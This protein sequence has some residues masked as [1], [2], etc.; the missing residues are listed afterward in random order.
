RRVTPA[1]PSALEGLTSVFGKGTG[2]SPPPLSPNPEIIPR[3][4][5]HPLP[6]PSTRPSPLKGEG[7]AVGSLYRGPERIPPPH[8]LPGL[9]RCRAQYSRLGIN[10]P[11]AAAPGSKALDLAT[12]GRPAGVTSAP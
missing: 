7:L 5:A 11:R 3:T 12:R 4:G 1:V 9:L 10:L 6:A 2:V 8:P